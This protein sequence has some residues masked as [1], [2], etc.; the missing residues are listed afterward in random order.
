MFLWT[1][2]W[3]Y[4]NYIGR[5]LAR[6]YSLDLRFGQSVQ[7]ALGDTTPAIRDCAAIGSYEDTRPILSGGGF[8]RSAPTTPLTRL[9]TISTIE[10]L[11]V[12]DT[13]YEASSKKN[14]RFSSTISPSRDTAPGPC[15]GIAINQVQP[16][17]AVYRLIEIPEILV[18]LR[19]IAISHSQQA[20]GTAREAS[21][22]NLLSNRTF[23]CF[24]VAAD[25]INSD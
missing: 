11:L 5:V 9:G 13:R 20:R 6:C 7:E 22:S 12:D 17:D 21:L 1:T 4:A 25:T 24:G 19:W 10:E 2:P 3:I 8:L 18:I 15:S 16:G 23:Y 14:V